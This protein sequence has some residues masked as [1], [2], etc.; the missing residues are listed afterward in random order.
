MAPINRRDP[1]E[2]IDAHVHTGPDDATAGG[3]SDAEIY[4]GLAGRE[5]W[6]DLPSEDDTEVG[7]EFHY[8]Y[9]SGGN[10]RYPTYNDPRNPK[11]TFGDL[12]EHDVYV[13][14]NPSD[15]WWHAE[16]VRVVV[17]GVLGSRATYEALDGGDSQWLGNGPGLIFHLKRT[18]H[19]DDGGSETTKV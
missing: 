3:G 13:R 18:D 15:D 19:N 10:T 6:L 17:K 8:I 14:M 16:K 9:G 11:L 5:F 1:I 12:L 7:Q 4:L 2:S